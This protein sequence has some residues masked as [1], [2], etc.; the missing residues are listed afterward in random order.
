MNIL[1]SYI[2]VPTKIFTFILKALQ[3][4]HNIKPSKNM[5]YSNKNE[6]IYESI[7]KYRK[8]KRFLQ[9][10]KQQIE[11]FEYAFLMFHVMHYFCGISGLCLF[12]FYA[13]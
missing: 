6:L 12:A 8:H 2:L 3:V 7:Q 5:E 4:V 9:F 11:Y 1:D 13:K 10:V